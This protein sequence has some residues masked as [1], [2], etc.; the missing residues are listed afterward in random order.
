MTKRGGKI[1]STFYNRNFVTDEQ[2]MQDPAFYM[3]CRPF[4]KV[5]FKICTLDRFISE[6]Q[7]QSL[8]QDINSFLLKIMNTQKDSIFERVNDPTLFSFVILQVI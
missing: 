3:Q 7:R 5:L 4:L 2:L 8:R 1:S 6:T